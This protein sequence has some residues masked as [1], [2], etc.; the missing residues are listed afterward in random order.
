LLQSSVSI[1]KG[2]A[3]TI[4]KRGNTIIFDNVKWEFKIFELTYHEKSNWTRIKLVDPRGRS[5]TLHCLLLT[6]CKVSDLSKSHPKCW[7]DEWPGTFAPSWCKSW[8]GAIQKSVCSSFG[9][10][11]V[12][13]PI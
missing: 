1:R 8:F 13:I 6:G 2:L 7:V 9:V 11:N 5:K 3:I 4:L 10:D 12:E